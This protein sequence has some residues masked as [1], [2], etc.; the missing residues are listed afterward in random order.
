M[1]KELPKKTFINEIKSISKTTDIKNNTNTKTSILNTETN[2]ITNK[3]DNSMP[4][5]ID[6]YF[7]KLYT[8]KD[9]E[10]LTSPNKFNK[11]KNNLLHY[12][13]DFIPIEMIFELGS[14][15]CNK[16]LVLLAKSRKMYIFN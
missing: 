2:N 4:N 5:M 13:F 14:T 7:Y 11:L 8:L 1:K 3:I 12:L 10:S 6:P 9:N 16:R 15:L